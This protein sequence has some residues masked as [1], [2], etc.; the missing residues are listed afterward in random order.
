MNQNKTAV[1]LVIVSTLIISAIIYLA[2]I[3]DTRTTPFSDREEHK[4]VSQCR[5]VL[6]ECIAYDT[7]GNYYFTGPNCRE[8]CLSVYDFDSSIERFVKL[9]GT[10][11]LKRANEIC[12]KIKGNCSFR[13]LEKII[14]SVS[15]EANEK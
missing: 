4:I 13:E 8:Q 14:R 7:S 2:F 5:S 10:N 6:P 9:Y 12:G 15:S 1:L 11:N 3:Y